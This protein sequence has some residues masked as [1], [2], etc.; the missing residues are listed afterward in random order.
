MP[1]QMHANQ[2]ERTHFESAVRDITALRKFMDSFT[3]PNIDGE[4]IRFDFHGMSPIDQ[5][6]VLRFISSLQPS[7]ETDE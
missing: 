5:R 4:S 7:A 3:H 1:N 2:E 6:R